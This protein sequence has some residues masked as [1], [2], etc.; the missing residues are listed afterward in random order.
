MIAINTLFVELIGMSAGVS[1]SVMNAFHFLA[2]LFD[3]SRNVFG[4]KQ[5]GRE[6]SSIEE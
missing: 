6:S 4:D 5:T 1:I 2:H 3:G